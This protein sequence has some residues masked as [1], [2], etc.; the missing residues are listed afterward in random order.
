MCRSAHQ[1]LRSPELVTLFAGVAP[2]VRRELKIQ[3]SGQVRPLGSGG[4]PSRSASVS[5]R[6]EPERILIGQS[7]LHRINTAELPAAQRL[8]QKPV[9]LLEPRQ[10]VSM[11]ERKPLADIE[12]GIPRGYLGR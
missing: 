3:R 1:G 2:R 10:V 6:F 11:R 8:L 7:R 4:C 12:R 5:P 9:T